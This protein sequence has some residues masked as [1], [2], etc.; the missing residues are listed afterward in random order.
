MP[1]LAFLLYNMKVR[2]DRFPIE[3]NLDEFAPTAHNLNSA[4]SCGYRVTVTD[5]S[6][7]QKDSYVVSGE[8]LDG[9]LSLSRNDGGVVNVDISEVTDWFEGE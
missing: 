5:K 2:V 9:N 3:P 8:Y 7:V 4:G 1:T 6:T